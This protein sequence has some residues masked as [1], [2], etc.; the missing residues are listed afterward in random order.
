[1]VLCDR[2]AE[3]DFGLLIE[4]ACIEAVAEP[5]NTGYFPPYPIVKDLSYAI[6]R[7][8]AIQGCDLCSLI[9]QA[10]LDRMGTRPDPEQL[11]DD[12]SINM[13]IMLVPCHPDLAPTQVQCRA[14][15]VVYSKG[16]VPAHEALIGMTRASQANG[17]YVSGKRF[18]WNPSLWRSWM[19]DCMEM[20]DTCNAIK[21]NGYAPTRLIDIGST[22]TAPSLVE[23]YGRSVEYVAL[24]HCWGGSLP[25]RTT[26]AN[27]HD[28]LDAVPWKALP[29]T[30]QDA[31][32]VTRSMG[33]QYLWI[34]CLCIIQDSEEDWLRECAL[35]GDVYA[36][37]AL[38]VA[39]EG[40]Q[41]PLHGFFDA[42]GSDTCSIQVQW[43]TSAKPDEL[44]MSSSTTHRPYHIL[45]F[46]P[47][48]LSRRGWAL[49]ERVLSTRVL[50]MCGDATCFTCSCSESNDHV[51]WPMPLSNGH[52]RLAPP[53]M[54]DAA[55][56]LKDWH[57]LVLDYTARQFTNARDRLPAISGVARIIAERFGWKY[58]AGLWSH[59]LEGALLWWVLEPR[60]PLSINPGHYSGP[61]WSWASVDRQTYGR[62]PQT[63]GKQHPRSW[64]QD[65]E[66]LFRLQEHDWVSHYEVRHFDVEL[67]GEDPFAEVKA[68]RLTIVGNIRSIPRP[69]VLNPSWQP[70]RFAYLSGS[71]VE[72]TYRPDRT[73]PQ[74]EPESTDT[75]TTCL[76]AGFE[77]FHIGHHRA[78]FCY[79]IVLQAVPGS[80]HTF[81]RIGMLTLMRNEENGEEWD[82]A[83]DWLLAA[84]TKEIYLV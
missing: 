64:I 82:K 57:M 37:A 10:L 13:S 52:F 26:M 5:T 11:T 83:I 75:E 31:V 76:L 7:L 59:D 6:L 3:I 18:P 73:T 27:F 66:S 9:Q 71:V 45:S 62:V 70:Q 16:C 55:Q 61:S 8:A 81:R 84:E 17:Q 2:C 19:N 24:S 20:H 63:L 49:Q 69:A 32:K 14:L 34:D 36:G 28:H 48:P 51:P 67:A 12:G 47:G 54:L 53:H 58:V 23:S 39:A 60:I 22:D 77:R 33:Y 50:Y 35:M 44:V 41:S 56:S 21:Q 65:K 68:G 79:A 30:F 1:M 4:R 74:A 72:V 40:S 78:P 43:P 29:P 42:R 80:T 38:T 25:L 15:Q 46:W